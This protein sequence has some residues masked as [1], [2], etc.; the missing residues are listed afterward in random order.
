VYQWEKFGA[1][2]GRLDT[3][4]IQVVIYLPLLAEQSTPTTTTLLVSC[5]SFC[6]VRVATPPD[7]CNF[8]INRDSSLII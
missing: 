2:G 3:L 6:M 4:S 1:S 7:F 5:M 8:F